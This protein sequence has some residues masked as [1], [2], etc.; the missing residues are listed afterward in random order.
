MPIRKV[1]RKVS[2]LGETQIALSLAA[3]AIVVMQIAEQ[4]KAPVEDPAPGGVSV[5]PLQ[6]VVPLDDGI[7]IGEQLNNQVQI[8]LSENTGY[9]FT[10]NSR[11]K[12]IIPVT[13]T[14]KVTS[15][16]VTEVLPVSD[17][18]SSLIKQS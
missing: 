16:K 6:P 10:A 8:P 11:M 4:K 18:D 5:E 2:G 9:Q 15:N 13:V 17:S 1:N 14:I 7:Y 3:L 12:N